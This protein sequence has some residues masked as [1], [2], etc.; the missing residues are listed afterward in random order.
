MNIIEIIKKRQTASN[1]SQRPIEKDIIERVANAVEFSP[2]G[3]EK[4]PLKLL[5]VSKPKQKKEI[6]QAAEQVE[7]AYL[8]GASVFDD[9]NGNSN[10]S[11]SS[12]WKKPFLEEAQNRIGKYKKT[13][14]LAK[15][16]IHLTERNLMNEFKYGI[17]VAESGPHSHKHRKSRTDK[18]DKSINLMRL[19]F[20]YMYCILPA[21]GNFPV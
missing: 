11:D 17:P 13:D 8:Q 16:R 4:I 9:S 19:K 21:D 5:V 7:R 20:H 1:F 12:D 18:K 15:D 14:I 2:M 6:R 10:S 3:S